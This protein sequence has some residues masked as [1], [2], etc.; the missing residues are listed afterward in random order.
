MACLN[1]RGFHV[2]GILFFIITL[3]I[4]SS[5]AAEKKESTRI[6]A[7]AD[8]ESSTAS[9]SLSEISIS[10]NAS[11]ST[12]STS[13]DNTTKAPS[14]TLSDSEASLVEKTGVTW[15][16]ENLLVPAP[17]T[18]SLLAQ[19]MALSTKNID[20]A[21]RGSSSSK[22]NQQSTSIQYTQSFRTTLV[23]ISHKLSNAFF[24][25]SKNS[26]MIELSLLT[27]P[28]KA[29]EAFSY[30]KRFRN[31]TRF[32]KYLALPLKSLKDTTDKTFDLSS[33]TVK[34]FLELVQLVREVNEIV[35]FSKTE[36][37]QQKGAVLIELQS[38][39]KEK[40]ETE[41]ELLIIRK[42]VEK[43]KDQL[44]LHKV[45][46]DLANTDFEQLK[47]DL[48]DMSRCY[49]SWEDS[50]KQ[51]E[52]KCPYRPNPSK[53]SEAKNAKE[54]PEKEFQS[55][56]KELDEKES[57]AREKREID[58]ELLIKMKQLFFKQRQLDDDIQLLEESSPILNGL[59]GNFT[60]LKMSWLTFVTM[61]EVIKEG[62]TK[63]YATVMEIIEDPSSWND[64][65]SDELS[66]QV[67]ATLENLSLLTTIVQSYLEG[68]KRHIMEIVAEA[69]ETL[70]K[71]GHPEEIERD[72]LRKCDAASGEIQNFI[73]SNSQLHEVDSQIAQRT[74]QSKQR[75]RN[76][77]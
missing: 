3:A 15:R 38:T 51:L 72:L 54:A 33:Q 28:G 74:K 56:M 27:A 6:V 10:A 62:A 22:R 23:Q 73:Q 41:S 48:N 45:Q 29:R 25:A 50:E 47:V 52:Y 44:Q 31:S 8:A 9:A 18:V 21:F 43:L 57:I 67:Q 64:S 12:I 7:A 26:E 76:D 13:I 53:I 40:N 68:Y 58:H 65:L 14:V 71:T 49:W 34:Q 77:Y 11:E 20:T 32:A 75:L 59:V 2:V 63:S 39:Q 69:E 36:K 4:S 19:L 35:D 55:T 16:T 60:L 61:C 24:L 37:E 70:V 46:L 17:R 30:L 66:L 42:D 5:S 1:R